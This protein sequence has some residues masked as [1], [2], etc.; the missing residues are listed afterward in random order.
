MVALVEKLFVNFCAVAM[1]INES[2][3]GKI[4]VV[5]LAWGFPPSRGSG[6][7]RALF[8][9]NF[10][11]EEGYRVTV[12][13]PEERIWN[14]YYGEDLS[15]IKKIDP[16][17]N[18]VRIPFSWDSGEIDVRKFGLFRAYQPYLWARY[19]YLK[20]RLLYPEVVYGPWGRELSKALVNIGKTQRVDLLLATANP[21][22]SSVAAWKFSTR[23]KI[24][25]IV[26]YRDAWTLNVFTGERAHSIW[27][28]QARVEKKVFRDAAEIWFVNEAIAEWHKK[29]YPN[30]ANRMKV[31]SNGWDYDLSEVNQISKNSYL[32]FGY[33]G[34]I[35]N[36][37]PLGDFLNA[38]IN[39]M[40]KNPQFSNN[41]VEFYGYLGF[42][43]GSNGLHY[44]LLEQAQKYNVSFQG[45]LE[46]EKLAAAYS[47]FD[48]CLLLLA[49]GKYVTSGKVYEYVSTTLP[50]LAIH[51]P[52][53]AATLVLRNHPATIK[54]KG[55]EIEQIEEAILEAFHKVA[56]MK[57]CSVSIGR[58]FA[59]DF[60][61]VE[62]L[63]PRVKH[64]RKIV[65]D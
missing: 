23:K 60:S 43:K 19:S 3:A 52:T 12:I 17:I 62:Q 59:Q 8:T 24:P 28:R 35:S 41:R 27:S 9:A 13:T 33:I 29:Q 65:D 4:H 42:Y 44:S 22:I 58:I 16:R 21:N 5:F 55:M 31:V 50:I 7:Y 14:H 64:F 51:E 57:A 2:I 20:E 10:L 26:D 49:S 18:V 54:T 56:S 34:T 61:R 46:K 30:E 37:V 47:N 6:V 36:Q 45:P 1:S 15:L 40:E 32:T 53:N 38:W 25:Y 48:C 11:A 39:V 63:K